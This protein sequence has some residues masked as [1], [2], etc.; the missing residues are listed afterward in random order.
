MLFWNVLD[1]KID[2]SFRTKTNALRA[3]KT[4]KSGIC[5]WKCYI[6]VVCVTLPTHSHNCS[7]LYWRKD[8]HYE[9]I[10]CLLQPIQERNWHW[11]WRQCASVYLMCWSRKESD[12]HKC[13]EGSNLSHL[14][15]KG[16]QQQL[17][18]P[19]NTSFFNS[20]IRNRKWLIRWILEYWFYLLVYYSKRLRTI[21]RLYFIDKSLS[22]SINFWLLILLARGK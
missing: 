19:S 17:F 7:L 8:N 10:L 9:K 12:S 14:I 18:F 20:C 16:C 13:A 22:S 3:W 21:Y 6:S 11:F 4:H 15:Q 2:Y 1:C 5:V